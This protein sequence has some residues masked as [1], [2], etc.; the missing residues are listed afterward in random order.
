MEAVPGGEHIVTGK[1]RTPLQFSWPLAQI[2]LLGRRTDIPQPYHPFG[3]EP[4][5]ESQTELG[6]STDSVFGYMYTMYLTS[7][8]PCPQMLYWVLAT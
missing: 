1:I 6:V 2:V 5:L 3:K 8:I 4:V 7:I